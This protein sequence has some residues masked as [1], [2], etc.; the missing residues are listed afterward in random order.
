MLYTKSKNELKVARQ[1]KSLG[2]EVYAPVR[3][4]VRQWSDRKKKI[5]VPL[6]PSMLLVRLLETEINNVFKVPSVRRY[7]FE[8]SKRCVVPNRE[9]LA[10]KYYLEGSFSRQDSSLKVG[11]TVEVPLLKKQAT[12]IALN[13]KK[14]LARLEQMGAAVSFQLK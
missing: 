1:L 11:D 4:E 8:N 14:C 10:M 5:E 6:L 12:V 2:I 3:T 7:L 9:V 13:G